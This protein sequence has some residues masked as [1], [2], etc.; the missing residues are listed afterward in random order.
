[1]KKIKIYI[2]GAGQ[3]YNRFLSYLA[4]YTNRFEVL[5]IV[6]TERQKIE[7]LDTYPC[8]VA[9]EMSVE[10]VDYIIIAI[11]KWQGIVGYLKEFGIGDDKIIPSKVFSLP[12]FDLDAYIQLKKEKVTILSNSCL[13]AFI[14]KELG[15]VYDSPTIWLYCLGD[16]Y[17]KF[18]ENYEYYLSKEMEVLAGDSEYKGNPYYL[19]HLVP[20]GII[21]NEVIWDFPHSKDAKKT[22][23]EWNQRRKRCNFDNVV[24]LMIIHTDEEALYFEK[25]PYKKKLGIYYKDLNYSS[26]V[27]C[28]EWNDIEIKHKHNYMWIN[29]VHSH[30][31]LTRGERGKINWI[32]FLLG[33]ENFI[34]F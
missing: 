1:M 12:Y 14:Y 27:C 29:Y 2:Y 33:Q 7:Y 26:I 17:L 32:K 34:R 5:G 24:I 10:D 18:I 20:K 31:L 23:D 6:T 28:S 22:V 8:I 16:H 19:E 15:L 13:G 4:A 3:E 25:L 21:D 30:M 9:S 11:E